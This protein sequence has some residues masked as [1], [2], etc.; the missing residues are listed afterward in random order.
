MGVLAWLQRAEIMEKT[1]SDSN[2]FY[3]A[4]DIYSFE[5]WECVGLEVMCEVRWG[6]LGIC[7]GECVYVCGE[8]ENYARLG[9]R[10]CGISLILKTQ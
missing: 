8:C 2:T 1:P 7:V 5:N 4:H 3:A 10:P 9:G 6:A